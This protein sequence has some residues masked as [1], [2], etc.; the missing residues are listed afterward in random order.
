VSDLE[1][2]LRLRA[3]GKGFVGEVTKADKTIGQFSQSIDKSGKASSRASSGYTS[4]AKGINSIS[5]QLSI[6]QK[7]LLSFIG[8]QQA[9][10]VTKSLINL[11]DQ[12]TLVNARLRLV[13]PSTREFATAQGE[14]FEIAQQTRTSFDGTVETYTRLAR[15]TQS[16]GISS[17]QLASVTRTIN[18]ALVVSGTSAESANAALIQLGQGLASG[19]LRGEELNSVLEQAPRLA[20]AIAKGMGKTVGQLR[21]LGAQGRITAENVVSSLLNQRKAV[22]TEFNQ[23]PITVGQALVKVSNRFETFIGNISRSTG[24]TKSLAGAISTLA[25]NINVLGNA[26]V[27]L[28]KI[29]LVA[30]AARFLN[31]AKPLAKFATAMNLVKG[32]AKALVPVLQ[33][34][35]VA[36]VTAMASP[37]KTAS[38]AFTLLTRGI[39]ASTTATR[40]LFQFIF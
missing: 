20:E 36:A 39:A 29:A 12:Y 3:D 10:R 19:T 40:I 37:L 38:V 9:I 33:L 13:A 18:Q 11:A 15:A 24:A 34:G 5:R 31:A 6:A 8:A 17:S 21:L 25:D 2:K 22:E 32:A 7:S 23:M 1:L 16:L 35:L 30:F 26:I 28:S 4:A 27:T 14:L